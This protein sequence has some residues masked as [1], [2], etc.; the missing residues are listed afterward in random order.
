[1]RRDAH[2]WERNPRPQTR[3]RVAALKTT[4][5]GFAAALKMVCFIGL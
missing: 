2:G 3:Q 5:F 4:A 1:M